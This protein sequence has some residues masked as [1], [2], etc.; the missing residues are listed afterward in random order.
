MPVPNA[1]KI[2]FLDGSLNLGSGGDVIRVLLLDDST[3]YT[4]D[5]DTHDF[6]DDVLAAGTEMSG[7]GYTRKTVAGQTTSTDDTDDEGVF[8][9]DDVT[10]TDIDAGNIQ[11]VVVY[12]QIGGDD[13]TPADD[14]IITVLDDATVADLPLPT[15]GSD[16]T[17]NW[18]AEGIINAE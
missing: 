5:P 13:T 7:T 10:W 2:A 4:F 9:G 1:T 8:D 3:A 14:R 18:N 11:T 17:I 12:Q 15:N 6:V 16:V